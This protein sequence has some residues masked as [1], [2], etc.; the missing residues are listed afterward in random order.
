VT[1]NRVFEYRGPED[2]LEGGPTPWR[3]ETGAVLAA[4][5]EDVRQTLRTGW[6]DPAFDTAASNPV[7]FTAAWSAIR[8][9]VGKSFLLLARALRGQAAETVR[10]VSGPDL[11][12]QLEADL[13]EEDVRRIEDA[14]RASHLAAAKAQ[15]VVHALAR[16][17]RRDR[18]PGTGREEPPVRRGVPEWQR[19]IGAQ[20]PPGPSGGVLEEAA[21]ALGVDQEPMPLRLLVRWPEALTPLWAG[22]APIVA[23]EAWRDGAARLRRIVR[24]GVDTLPHP[25]DLQWSA[26]RDRG[27]SEEERLALADSL[28]GHDRSMADQT[29]MAAFAWAAM[30]APDIGVES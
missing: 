8:P 23:G 4:V 21:E 27:V 19:W 17:A 14:V 7:F 1:V 28:A 15:I 3:P 6:L 25:V 16:A 22:L 9:N 29:L 18:I 24:V 20:L 10:V 12:K 5:R 11:R 13:L 26:L 30:G 2:P